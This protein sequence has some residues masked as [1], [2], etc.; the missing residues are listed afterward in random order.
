MSQKYQFPT[1]FPAHIL[2]L[3]I[4]NTVKYGHIIILTGEGIV[5][6]NGAVQTVIVKHYSATDGK[7]FYMLPVTVKPVLSGHSKIDKTKN[8]MTNEPRHNIFNNVVCVTSKASDQPAHTRSLIRAFDGRLNI[9][10]L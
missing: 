7:I 9:L 4:S 10:I 5:Y 3:M 8:L 1:S 2:S 6:Q